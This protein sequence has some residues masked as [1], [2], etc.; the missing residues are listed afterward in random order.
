MVFIK[1][2]ESLENKEFIAICSLCPLIQIHIVLPLFQQ[3]IR[4]KKLIIWCDNR[5]TVMYIRIYNFEG[6]QNGK[7]HRQQAKQSVV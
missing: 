6:L 1:L 5:E 4:T 2:S 7:V 3:L